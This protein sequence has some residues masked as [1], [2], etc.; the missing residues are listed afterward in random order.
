L[1]HQKGRTKTSRCIGE[2]AI[3]QRDLTKQS[4]DGRIARGDFQGL[5][6]VAVRQRRIALLQR[7]GPG[8]SA[9][10]QG[11]IDLKRLFNAVVAS[12]QSRSSNRS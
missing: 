2:S 11:G 1:P 6:E 9:L 12:A 4:L 8:E 3:L 7:R 5:A 10:N